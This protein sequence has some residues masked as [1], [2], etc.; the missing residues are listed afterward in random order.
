MIE[1]Y[2][3]LSIAVVLEIGH[4]NRRLAQLGELLHAKQRRR[5]FYLAKAFHAAQYTA[6]FAR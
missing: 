1:R 2:G 4:L 3:L 6:F 5:L